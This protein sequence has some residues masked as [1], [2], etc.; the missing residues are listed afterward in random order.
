MHTRPIQRTP[1]APGQSGSPPTAG[2][3]V[4]M[5]SHLRGM[6]FDEGAA[7]L[8]PAAPSAPVQL[9]SA[10]QPVQMDEEEGSAEGAGGGYS[11]P[12]PTESSEGGGDSGAEGAGGGGDI[13]PDA[14]PMM[15]EE[16]DGGGDGEYSGAE[17]AGG[18]GEYSSAEGAGGG[19]YSSAEGG[20]EYSGAGGA[21][22][23]YSG[24]EGAGGGESSASE[25]EESDGAGGAGGGTSE[26]D[27]GQSGAEG[28]G[29]GTSESES[30]Q[31]E[32]EAEAGGESESQPESG[33][34]K[35]EFELD[36]E[37]A[38]PLTVRYKHNTEDV[39]V[40]AEVKAGQDVSAGFGLL[41]LV[42]SVEATGKGT[43]ARKWEGGV[44]QIDLGVEAKGF[45]GLG[46][47]KQHDK[48]FNGA[49]GGVQ[50]KAGATALQ[51]TL[52]RKGKPTFQS[53]SPISI[54]AAPVMGIKF[55]VGPLAGKV[56]YFPN[57]EYELYQVH[58]VGGKA[59][60]KEGAGWARMREE[61]AAW[62]EA[63]R[64]A[65][66]ENLS[67]GGAEGAPGAYPS[68]LEERQDEDGGGGAGGSRG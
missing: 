68:E 23:E 4:Q 14:G 3:G 54:K 47:G 15:S 22:G 36:Y 20:G 13:A 45:L 44:V 12:E 35:T 67:G 58:F 46:I 41:N 17:G 56:E 9:K 6:S 60:W 33:E 65:N 37:V 24:A 63:R 31:T 49:Y 39:A 64:Q 42:G 62:V 21:G 51:V 29:G 30:E 1:K 25:D 53:S 32:A 55:K 28:A 2:G 10:A 66:I 34:D 26:S 59:V 43:F 57:N 19:E 16:S 38:G 18:G 5:R 52:P 50:I 27:Y 7:A 40:E 11:A 61:Y 48:D 8:A